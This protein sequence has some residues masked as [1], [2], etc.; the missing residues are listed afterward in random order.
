MADGRGELDC[1]QGDQGVSQGTDG[2]ALAQVPAGALTGIC[3]SN[4]LRKGKLLHWT[5]IG[6]NPRSSCITTP[7]RGLGQGAPLC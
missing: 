5:E 6:K 7:H 1:V 2:G 4:I 3:L